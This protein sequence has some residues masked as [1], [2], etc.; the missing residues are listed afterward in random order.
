[1]N[2]TGWL[3][4]AIL[5]ALCVAACGGTS[6]GAGDVHGVEAPSRVGAPLVNASTRGGDVDDGRMLAQKFQCARCHGGTPDAVFSQVLHCVDCHKQIT[7]GTFTPA[8]PDS[9]LARWKTNVAPFDEVPSL[10]VMRRF[11]R[12]WL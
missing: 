2:A 5:A 3:A 4:C 7:S 12:E 11:K 8:P 10:L 6:S 1:M 9:V